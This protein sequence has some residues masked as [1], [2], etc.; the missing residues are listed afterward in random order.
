M[1]ELDPKAFR[2]KE[3]G[4]RF[5]EQKEYLKALNC[6]NKAL[7]FEPNSH[8]LWYNRGIAY[9]GLAYPEKQKKYLLKSAEALEKAAEISPGFIEAHL[10]LMTVYAGLDNTAKIVDAFKKAEEINSNHPEVKRF[11]KDFHKMEVLREKTIEAYSDILTDITKES[12]QKKVK[13]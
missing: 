13:K 4:N 5:L 10:K 12:K 9:L 1:S 8:F 3:E 6:Y 2:L 11:A 7:E